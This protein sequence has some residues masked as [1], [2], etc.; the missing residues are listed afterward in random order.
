MLWVAIVVF[1]LVFL[2]AMTLWLRAR[3]AGLER[4]REEIGDRRV[5]GRKQA[6]TIVVIIAGAAAAMGVAA[7]AGFGPL[8]VL[9][10]SFVVAATFAA[11]LHLTFRD[12]GEAQSR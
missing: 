4:R 10:G 2:V 7:L 12:A 6:R 9:L 3:L 5:D 8:G 11:A 1:W